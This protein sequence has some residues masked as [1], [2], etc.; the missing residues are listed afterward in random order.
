[1]DIVEILSLIVMLAVAAVIIFLIV[2]AVQDSFP[3]KEAMSNSEIGG[4]SGG[5]VAAI[6]VGGFIAYTVLHARRG[7]RLMSGK[8]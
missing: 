8:Y 7:L 1:M 5:I 6:A 2:R 3:K 4:L